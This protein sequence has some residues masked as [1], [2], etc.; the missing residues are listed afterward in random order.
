M[1]HSAGRNRFVRSTANDR[2]SVLEM[3]AKGMQRLI[4]RQP[5]LRPSCSKSSRRQVRLTTQFQTEEQLPSKKMLSVTWQVVEKSALRNSVKWQKMFLLLSRWQRFAKMITWFYRK[6]MMPSRNSLL[7]V[8]KFWEVACFLARIG[9]P[10]FRRLVNT[11]A[12]SFTKRHEAGDNNIAKV[13][14]AHQ[15]NQRLQAIL[16]CGPW[17]LKIA[18]IWFVPR[19]FICRWLSRFTLN[20]RMCIVCIWITS[21]FSTFMVV[22]KSKPQFVKWVPSL[23]CFAW[24]RFTN[25]RF[26]S[27]PNWR[28]CYIW[29][30]SA[31]VVHS[32]SFTY[33]HLCLPHVLANNLNRSLFLFTRRWSKSW[34]KQN[35]LLNSGINTA[36][37]CWNQITLWMICFLWINCADMVSRTLKARVT[38]RRNVPP[39]ESG[40]Q[41]LA[42]W[43]TVSIH[44][45]Q[46]SWWDNRSNRQQ[47]VNMH[48]A[49]VHVFSETSTFWGK[50]AM[51]SPEVKI[52]KRWKVY[53][54]YYKD[55][56]KKIDGSN[57]NTQYTF[58][59]CQDKRDYAHNRW[60]DSTKNLVFQLRKRKLQSW[61]KCDWWHTAL[62]I[63]Q[64]R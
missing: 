37:I 53:L 13:D 42:D 63:L 32:F 40:G 3:H 29:A 22:L 6:I 47:V 2:S 50:S 12:R 33:W 25:R 43:V 52:A 60:M 23:N 1:E 20:F 59:W 14:Q 28:M 10:D 58:S 48:E 18:N 15:S 16:S 61:S 55:T 46:K 39:D 64:E 30:A 27:T 9:R 17:E 8:L 41:L 5:S 56:A 34:R 51:A 24:E 44:V 26:T 31:R 38:F 36:Q 45:Q 7:Y 57:C 19:C 21:V 35:V 4:S 54:E 49:E 11:V 62:Q